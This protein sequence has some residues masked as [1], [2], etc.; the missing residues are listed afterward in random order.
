MCSRQ[1][2]KNAQESISLFK[3]TI[4]GSSDPVLHERLAKIKQIA[5]PLVGKTQVCEQLSPVGIVESFNT[6]ELDDELVVDLLS[7]VPLPGAFPWRAWRPGES[8]R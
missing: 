4:D 7:S 8:A 6:L 5:R 2:A 1:D 3:G